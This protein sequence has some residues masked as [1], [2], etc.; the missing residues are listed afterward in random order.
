MRLSSRLAVTLIVIRAVPLCSISGSIRR[1][2]SYRKGRVAL[3]HRDDV[4]F[5]KHCLDGFI[6]YRARPSGRR[7]L[8]M[9]DLRYFE[10]LGVIA[11]LFFWPLISAVF[12]IGEEITMSSPTTFSPLYDGHRS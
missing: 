6:D 9:P 2:C 7:F 3:S 8:V 1:R 11:V 12:Q 5:F 10:I 4:A